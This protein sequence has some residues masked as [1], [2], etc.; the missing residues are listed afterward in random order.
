MQTGICLSVFLSVSLSIL[1]AL[2]LPVFLSLWLYVTKTLF[3][4]LSAGTTFGCQPVRDEEDDRAGDAG[5]RAADCK[6]FSTQIRDAG[7]VKLG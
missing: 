5:R 2:F 7:K 6:C 1:L 4:V 3:F